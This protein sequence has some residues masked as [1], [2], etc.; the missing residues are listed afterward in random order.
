MNWLLAISYWFHLLTTVLWLGGLIVMAL[1]AFP[2]WRQQTLTDNQWVHLQ[3]RLVPYI[4]LSMAILW[5]T[6]FYQMTVDEAYTG[7]LTIDSTWAIAILLKHVAV[8]AMTG[9]GL[10]TQ[11][12]I[13]PSFE[14]L[15]L[16]RQSKPKRAATE[17]AQLQAQEQR[18]LRVNLICAVAVLFFTAIATAA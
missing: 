5:V 8:V 12:R 11:F 18:L 17:A 10:Y 15:A 16:L 3:S 14:R 13:L 2:A 7:F 4:N 1:I 9:I 6:G